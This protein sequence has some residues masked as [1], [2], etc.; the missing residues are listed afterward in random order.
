VAVKVGL[1]FLLADPC[2]AINPLAKI[3]R[4]DPELRRSCQRLQFRRASGVAKVAMARKLAFRLY[5]MLRSPKDYA[6]L[7]R[8]SLSP[9]SDVVDRGPS[10]DRL[11]AGHPAR[12]GEIEARIM[13]R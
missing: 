7:V 6:H 9:S 2:Q 13:V 4:F 8:M 1:Q 3:H 12:G 11:S 10:T 5:W